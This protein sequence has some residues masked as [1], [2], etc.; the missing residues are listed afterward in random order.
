MS[1][2]VEKYFSLSHKEQISLLHKELLEINKAN[3]QK[4]G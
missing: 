2:K 3:N 1:D 4:K